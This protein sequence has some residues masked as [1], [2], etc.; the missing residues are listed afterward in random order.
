MNRMRKDKC[1]NQQSRMRKDKCAEHHTR[2]HTAMLRMIWNILIVV[3]GAAGAGAA[4][5]VLA[6]L[7]A[8]VLDRV[9]AVCLLCFLVAMIVNA[10]IDLARSAGHG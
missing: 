9:G 8:P 3:V 6:G 5:M 10:L 1:A 7:Y 4:M 2:G